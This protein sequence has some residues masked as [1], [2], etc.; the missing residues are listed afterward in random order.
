MRAGWAARGRARCGAF[1]TSAVEADTT[2]RRSG[3]PPE[4]SARSAWAAVRVRE[5]AGHLDAYGAV[6]VDRHAARRRELAQ[7]RAVPPHGENLVAEWVAA[8]GIAARPE[9]HGPGDLVEHNAELAVDCAPGR[10]AVEAAGVVQSA[11][12]R[13]VCDLA[14]V[15]TE[16]VDG[17]DLADPGR[18]LTGRGVGRR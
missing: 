2:R 15:A 5:R 12:R 9:Q 10:A 8:D 13:E 17:E 7:P 18:V 4:R 11:V 1:R 16:C 6:R 14:Q 3:R